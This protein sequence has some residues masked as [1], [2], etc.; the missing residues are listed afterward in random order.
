MAHA[1]SRVLSCAKKGATRTEVGSGERAAGRMESLSRLDWRDVHPKVSL[2]ENMA[3]SSI[4]SMCCATAGGFSAKPSTM[5][6]NW[7]CP[8]LSSGWSQIQWCVAKTS[9]WFDLVGRGR[10]ANTQIAIPRG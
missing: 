2:P 7:A 10:V 1:G 5:R 6:S 9:R 3:R 4:S 8:D